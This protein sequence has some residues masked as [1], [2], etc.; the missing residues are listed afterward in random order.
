MTSNP[1]ASATVIRQLWSIGCDG[2]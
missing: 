2:G 1:S